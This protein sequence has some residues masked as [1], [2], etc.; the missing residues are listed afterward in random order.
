MHSM[1]ASMLTEMRTCSYQTLL[2]YC[3][4]SLRVGCLDLQLSHNG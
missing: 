2:I 4:C 1:A 3:I